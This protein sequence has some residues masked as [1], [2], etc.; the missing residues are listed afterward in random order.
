M[1]LIMV[2]GEV[3][4]SEAST[5]LVV[6]LVKEVNSLIMDILQCLD[7]PF[8]PG[9]MISRKDTT[10]E[11]DFEDRSVCFIKI[12][13]EWEVESIKVGTLSFIEELR[14]KGYFSYNGSM[15]LDILPKP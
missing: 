6:T 4:S 9:Q 3:G 10:M 11:V 5:G 14:G 13:K 15:K 7:I 2:E 1:A 8:E 12:K